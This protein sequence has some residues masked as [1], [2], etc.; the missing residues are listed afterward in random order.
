M[1]AF[2]KSIWRAALYDKQN[3]GVDR[4]NVYLIFQEDLSA[5]DT[6]E[7]L[8]D[9]IAGR[10]P[11]AGPRLKFTVTLF[12]SFLVRMFV[13]LFVHWSHYHAFI[14]EFSFLFQY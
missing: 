6:E 14:R 13:S 9:L 1:K 8:D 10:T 12:K 5:E 7:I 2:S 3:L 4:W 11:K